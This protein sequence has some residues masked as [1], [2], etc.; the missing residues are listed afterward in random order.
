[1]RSRSSSLVDSKSRSE[2]HKV[3]IA[4]KTSASRCS[5]WPLREYKAKRSQKWDVEDELVAVAVP[6]DVTVD[7]SDPK[8][9]PTEVHLK[10]LGRDVDVMDIIR[11]LMWSTRGDS[12]RPKSW[13]NVGSE[14]LDPPQDILM[15]HARGCEFHDQMVTAQG[16]RRRKLLLNCGHPL[17][18]VTQDEVARYSPGKLRRKSRVRKPLV[19]V[20]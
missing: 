1:M 17:G 10:A 14:P 6:G 7:L 20:L 5:P 19:V 3:R 8:S 13:K 2:P 16:F 15:R 18:R 12:H 9:I 4:R 11:R